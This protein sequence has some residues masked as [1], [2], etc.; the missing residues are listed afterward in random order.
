[1]PEDGFS[2]GESLEERRR[3]RI[4]ANNRAPIF[5]VFENIIELYGATDVLWAFSEFA[6]FMEEGADAPEPKALPKWYREFWK[7]A[8]RDLMSLTDRAIDIGLD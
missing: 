7:S 5:E 1:M 4:Q 6:D 2:F 3:K 8:S